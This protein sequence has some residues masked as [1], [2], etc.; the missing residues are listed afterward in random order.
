MGLTRSLFCVKSLIFVLSFKVV[1]LD[2]VMMT[3]IGAIGLFGIAVQQNV[4]AP[5]RPTPV[6]LPTSSKKVVEMVLK[7]GIAKQGPV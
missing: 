3:R 6:T 4:T 2:A 1:L 5:N 7:T